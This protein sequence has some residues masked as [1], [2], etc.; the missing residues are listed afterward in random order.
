MLKSAID[1]STDLAEQQQEGV[2]Q[3]DTRLKNIKARE[4]EWLEKNK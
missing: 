2:R 4:D 1:T 3:T